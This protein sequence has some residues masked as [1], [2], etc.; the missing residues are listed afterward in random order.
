MS[1]HLPQQ[2]ESTL[3]KTAP[4]PPATLDLRDPDAVA[5][6][7]NDAARACLQSPGRKGSHVQLPR[8]GRLTIGGDLHDHALNLRRLVHLADLDASPQNH[9]VLQE[10]V[11]GPTHTNNMDFS[12]RSLARVAQLKARYP[13]Q[14]HVLMGNHELAQVQ[15]G[16]ISKH[17]LNVVE[18]FDQGLE[19]AFGEKTAIVRDAMNRFILAMLLAVKC[20]NGIIVTHSLPPPRAIDTF[21]PTILDRT[22]TPDDLKL[23]GSAYHMVWGRNH[24]D[25]VADKLA[26]A[27]GVDMFVMGH[28]P[29]EFGYEITNRRM[30]VL[31]SD[32]EHGMGLPI[33]LRKSYDM[34]GLI[35]SLVTLATV[36]T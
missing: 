24:N 4:P 18:A 14:V 10:I 2:P 1:D 34:D 19:F 8:T 5:D 26:Q 25:A 32:H 11:H 6:L 16:N 7:F 23:N 3:P 35:E 28:Q 33:D 15:K 12:Y 20:D 36:P 21:D 13:L 31:A 9:L 17:G 29:A 30:L 22:P 27:W